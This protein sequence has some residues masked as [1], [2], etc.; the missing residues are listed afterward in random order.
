MHAQVVVHLGKYFEAIAHDAA[1]AHVLVVRDLVD[2]VFAGI[3]IQLV[4][5][6]EQVVAYIDVPV[7]MQQEIVHLR[8]AVAER[9]LGELHRRQ[10]L[11]P[12]ARLRHRFRVFAQAPVFLPQQGSYF[13]LVVGGQA[14]AVAVHPLDYAQPLLLSALVAHERRGLLV[15][16]CTVE[17]EGLFQVGIA[18]E[19]EL[20]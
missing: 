16:E 9:P 6:V 13:L 15:A 5:T 3:G 2:S 19:I 20:G 18:A 10:M 12:P 8:E 7:R 4:D 14:G 17:L 11:L 1:Q